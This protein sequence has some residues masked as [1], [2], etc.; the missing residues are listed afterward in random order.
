M[1]TIIVVADAIIPWP[2]QSEGHMG[3]HRYTGVNVRLY[4]YLAP[5]CP[6]LSSSVLSFSVPFCPFSHI[7][8]YPRAL[9]LSCVELL[10][11]AWVWWPSLS[12]HGHVLRCTGRC[13][14]QATR[15]S[16]NAWCTLVG[17]VYL[18]TECGQGPC[19]VYVEIMS[20]TTCRVLPR[21]PDSL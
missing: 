15:M 5:S 20:V 8:S 2:W 11:S 12:H 7:Q 21:L 1:K 16:W 10:R 3:P 17:A 18:V 6:V 14:Y 13:W 19:S 9:S 4:L